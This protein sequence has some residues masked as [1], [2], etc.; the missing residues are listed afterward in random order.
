MQA[1]DIG[2]T[3]IVNLDRMAAHTVATVGFPDIPVSEDGSWVQGCRSVPTCVRG[4]FGGPG[5]EDAVAVFETS[6]MTGGII[7]PRR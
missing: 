1:V 6:D 4:G 5:H 2:V 3:G 7:A